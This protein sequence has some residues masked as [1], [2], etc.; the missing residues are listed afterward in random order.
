MQEVC[1]S[2]NHEKWTYFLD[3]LSWSQ[4]ALPWLQEVN[5]VHPGSCQ[6]SVLNGVVGEEVF[7]PCVT[8]EPVVKTT[9]VFWRDGNNTAVLNIEDSKE[10]SPSP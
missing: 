1:V 6:A 3:E 9:N 7:L 10:T 8:T 2:S 4:K 5:M